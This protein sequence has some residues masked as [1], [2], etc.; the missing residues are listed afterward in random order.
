MNDGQSG[1][2]EQQ[3]NDILILGNITKLYEFGYQNSRDNP[4][5]KSVIS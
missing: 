1:L 4:T 5:S 3:V 2:V